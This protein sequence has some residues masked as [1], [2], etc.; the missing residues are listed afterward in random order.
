MIGLGDKVSD[1]TIEFA[2]AL[3]KD[4]ACGEGD[5]MLAKDSEGSIEAFRASTGE[6][7]Q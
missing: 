7:F 5:I 4:I 6:V 3:D 1:S 2:V